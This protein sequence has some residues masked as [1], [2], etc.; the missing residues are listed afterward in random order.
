MFLAVFRFLDINALDF[1]SKA[2]KLINAFYKVKE[3]F[4]GSFG[5][6]FTRV[7]AEYTWRIGKCTFQREAAFR[8]FQVHQFAMS[9]HEFILGFLRINNVFRQVVMQEEVFL[10]GEDFSILI[11]IMHFL[12]KPA[13]RISCILI[14]IRMINIGKN[15]CHRGIIIYKRFKMENP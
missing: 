4:N 7:D 11:K 1:R 13:N 3:V 2:G 10:K 5:P 6:S 8:L 12:A 15:L 9:A 14:L